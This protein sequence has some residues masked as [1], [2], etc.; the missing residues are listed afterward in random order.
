MSR[1]HPQ[2]LA[3]L[4]NAETGRLSLRRFEREDLDALSV[5]F[6]KPE[7]W[8]FPF[9]RGFSRHETAQFL[10]YEIR[11]W[12]ACGFGCWLATEKSTGRIVGYIGISVPRYLPAVLPAVEVGWRLD[13]EVWGC[14]FATEG[15]TAALDAAFDRLGLDAVCAATQV[16]NLRS[17]LVCDRLGMEW[18]RVVTLAPTPRR[19][20]I[21]ANL[22]WMIRPQWLAKRAALH[23]GKTR[24]K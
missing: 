19:G 21:D 4:E 10:E 2:I 11:E 7:V 5:V 17:G 8:R 9:G 15:A 22:Y 1:A 12:Q 16:E 24:Q 3:P 6:A 20:A 23:A 13:T 14:G 18:E